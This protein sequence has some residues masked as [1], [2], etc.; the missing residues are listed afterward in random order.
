MVQIVWFKRDLRTVDHLPLAQAAAR[1]PILPLLIVEPDYWKQPDVSWRQW[2]AIRPAI[3]ELA[4]RLRELGSPLVVRT[5]NAASVF[6][7]L[8]TQHLITAVF[9]HEE[10]GNDFT[11]K[12]DIEVRA[13]LNGLAIPFHES[14]QFGVFRGLKDRDKWAGRHRQQMSAD[15]VPEPAR[16]QSCEGISSDQL[17]SAGNLSLE[18]DGCDVP[19]LGTRAEA[20]AR[21]SRFFSG[22]GAN[23]RRAM[24]TPLEGA[25]ACSRLSVS[26]STGA[27][28]MREVIQRC[29]AERRQLSAMPPSVRSVPLTAIDSLIA[30]LHW[31]CHF[32]QKLESQPELEWQSQ[33]VLHEVNRVKTSPDDPLL[34][35]WATGNTG[36][37]FVD[38]CMRSLIATGWLN[39]RMRAMVQCIASHHLALDWSVSGTRLARLF[40]DYEPGIHWSQ[41][42]MQS[43][44]TGINIPR[45][46]NPIK[47]GLDQDPEGIFTRR[48]VPE[49]SQVPLAFLQ[50]P[51]KMDADCQQKSGCILGLDYPRPVVDPI[52]AA[53]AARDRLTEVRRSAGY[54][55]EAKRVFLQH[56]S[57]KRQTAR[58]APAPKPKA[59]PAKPAAQDQLILDF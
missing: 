46:Y 48:W 35:A 2:Q 45:I 58:R 39:F 53:R 33:H 22:Q 24:S 26:L 38:A 4:L 11:F 20:M 9:A 5:G 8:H 3:Q 51:W 43:G 34:I 40:T 25:E 10:T 55:T 19:Q 13:F 12:R 57:R 14:R 31:H 37:P 49:L 42:Q 7:K 29:Y 23:Y 17:P 27:I 15:I 59:A 21:L 50:E 41:V 44:Q 32:I 52:E 54:R 1:G 6:Q 28:S 36:L 47:Q 18:R 16:L 56:G 30:R